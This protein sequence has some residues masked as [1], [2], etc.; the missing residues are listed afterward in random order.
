[1]EDTTEDLILP[2]ESGTRTPASPRDTAA[3]QADSAMATGTD[4]EPE[5]SIGD[6]HD[7]EAVPDPNGDG[8]LTLNEAAIILGEEISHDDQKQ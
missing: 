1:M 3:L 2:A 5:M 6:K 8:K 4:D 7:G